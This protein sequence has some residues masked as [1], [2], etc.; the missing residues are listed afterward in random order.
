[1]DVKES[2]NRIIIKLH[3]HPFISANSNPLYTFKT[4]SKEIFDL[5]KYKTFLPFLYHIKEP[6][7]DSE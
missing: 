4:A 3:P 5:S 2:Y 1:M 7:V 6:F